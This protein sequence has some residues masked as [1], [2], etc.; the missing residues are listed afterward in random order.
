MKAI[1][2]TKNLN[3]QSENSGIFAG[4]HGGRCVKNAPTWGRFGGAAALLDRWVQL[5]M[6]RTEEP[7]R[8][9]RSAAW[10][11]THGRRLFAQV[12][13]IGGRQEARRV[14]TCQASCKWRILNDFNLKISSWIFQLFRQLW[15]V[16]L[17]LRFGQVQ[18]CCPSF[19]SSFNPL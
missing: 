15:N 9:E 16:L 6:R 17:A 2:H 12:E 3:G 5:V 7:G 11:L 4:D 10:W 19:D 13:A 18:S 14:S 8:A 1:F